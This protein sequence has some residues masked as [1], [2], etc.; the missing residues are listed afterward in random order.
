MPVYTCERCGKTF[1]QKGH[2]TDHLNRK[3]PCKEVPKELVDNQCDICMKV[4]STNSNYHKHRKICERKNAEKTKEAELLKLIDALNQKVHDDEKLKEDKLSELMKIVEDQQK[5]LTDLRNIV[6]KTSQSY[7]ITKTQKNQCEYCDKVLS[8]NSNYHKHIRICKEKIAQTI[9]NNI[10]NSINDNSIHNNI[11]ININGFG[12]ED[13]KGL[14]NTFLN[15]LCGFNNRTVIDMVEDI[16]HNKKLPHN[17]NVYIGDIKSKYAIVYNGEEWN[18]VNRDEVIDKLIKDKYY[19][20]EDLMNDNL[21]KLE[22]LKYKDSQA[23]KRF[24]EFV[25]IMYDDER[26][27]DLNDLK[28]KIEL[29]LYN[30]RKV[31]KAHRKEHEKHLRTIEL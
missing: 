23:Y 20:L 13:L 15:R 26:A 22:K 2:Y 3:N 18:L 25:N 8:T 12:K 19:I 31:L 21:E 14:K 30:K 10:D 6:N 27:E 16:H 5:E 9:N 29:L 17:Q 4:L 7:Q 28:E 1:D 11:N 24:I